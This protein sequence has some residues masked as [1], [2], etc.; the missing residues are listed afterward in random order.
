M[1]L[2]EQPN[3]LEIQRK[4]DFDALKEIS[5]YQ[6]II[7]MPNADTM[8]NMVRQELNAFISESNNAIGV[9]SFG[10]LGYLSCMKYCVMML[11]NTSSGFIEASFFNKYVINIGNRQSGRIL[12]ANIKNCD[13]KKSEILKAVKAYKSYQLDDHQN[14]YG[15]GIAGTKIVEILKSFFSE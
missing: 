1:W 2:D 9:E 11:G 7:T 3:I 6:L 15:D 12:T 8:G 13:I 10:A 5:E 4:M 14:I